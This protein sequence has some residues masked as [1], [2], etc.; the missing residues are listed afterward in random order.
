MKFHLMLVHEAFKV[1]ASS[2]ERGNYEASDLFLSTSVNAYIVGELK[3][4]G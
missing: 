3:W 4:N 2:Q 1:L